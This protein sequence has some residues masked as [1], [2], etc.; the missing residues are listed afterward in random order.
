M[1]KVKVWEVVFRGR[2]ISKLFWIVKQCQVVGK[3]MVAPMEMCGKGG[4]KQTP[5]TV[6]LSEVG[7]EAERIM[8]VRCPSLQ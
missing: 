1:N 7:L 6:R 5:N 3:P 8:E 2:E 4:V